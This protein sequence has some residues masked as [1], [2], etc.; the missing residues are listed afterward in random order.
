[1]RDLTAVDPTPSLS[2]LPP[3]ASGSPLLPA[4]SGSPLSPEASGW[5]TGDSEDAA[6]SLSIFQKHARDE[7]KAASP[8]RAVESETVEL[9][10]VMAAP[11]DEAEGEG[12]G[13]V[14]SSGRVGVD[15]GGKG[16]DGA[17]LWAWHGSYISYLGKYTQL[18]H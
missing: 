8:R 4:S 15:R 16:W 3:A 6:L 12:S 1:M 18:S 13:A 2:P 7:V 10:A 14:V 5:E 9:D 11:V 17:G